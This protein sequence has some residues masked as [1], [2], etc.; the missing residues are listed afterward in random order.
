LKRTPHGEKTLHCQI[1]IEISIVEKS[2]K[3]DQISFCCQCTTLLETAGEAL[4][5]CWPGSIAR[6]FLRHC[7]PVFV[8]DA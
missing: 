3:K 7:V 8:S 1:D 4:S 2:W 6:H 5:L